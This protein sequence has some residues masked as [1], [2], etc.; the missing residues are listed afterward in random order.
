MGRMLLQEAAN[1]P[2]QVHVMERDEHC[3]AANLSHKF[4]NGDITAYEDVV[5]FG[6]GV[7]V[8][9]IEIENVNIEALEFL[10]TQGVKV[11]P[12]PSAPVIFHSRVECHREG[13]SAKFFALG[14]SRNA[15]SV[16]PHRCSNPLHF[17]TMFIT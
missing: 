15:H 17:S 14:T 7:D 8:L 5:K 6:E 3:P 4:I 1:Y 13:L 16:T 12:K 2:V 9:T 11:I 10:E